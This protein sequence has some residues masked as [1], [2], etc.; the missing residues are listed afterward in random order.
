M[1]GDSLSRGGGELV[2]V[3]VALVIAEGELAAIRMPSG[4]QEVVIMGESGL[5]LAGGVPEVGGGF[6]IA[7]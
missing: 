1:G 4:G 3:E 6:L 7:G 2:E 5:I